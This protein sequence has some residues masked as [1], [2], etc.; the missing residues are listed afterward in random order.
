MT[1]TKLFEVEGFYTFTLYDESGNIKQQTTQEDNL[2]L[3]QGL[4]FI[5]QGY[6]FVSICSVGSG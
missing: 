2:I 1:N 5:G 4:N 6:E 3:D